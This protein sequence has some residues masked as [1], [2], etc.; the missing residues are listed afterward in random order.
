M[1]EKVEDFWLIEGVKI[2]RAA[3]PITHLFFADDGI[4]F[5]KANMKYYLSNHPKLA[6]G[7]LGASKFGKN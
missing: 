7:L 1:L 2:A 3:P 5:S 6:K 4:I